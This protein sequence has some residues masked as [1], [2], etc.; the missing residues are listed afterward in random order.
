MRRDQRSLRP[1]EKK[2]FAKSIDVIFPN[3][4]INTE[5]NVRFI[6]F[7]AGPK[8]VGRPTDSSLCVARLRLIKNV[9]KIVPS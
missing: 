5:Q 6:T 1:G 2:I 3:E 4:R 8:H 7:I 9:I